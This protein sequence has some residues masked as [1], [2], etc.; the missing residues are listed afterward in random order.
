MTIRTAR[1]TFAQNLSTD[2][3]R[4]LVAS[5]RKSA[6]GAIVDDFKL[7][8]GFLYTQVRAI[9]ARVNQNYDGWPS[10]E[11]KK[12]YR[13]FLGKPDFV[14]HQNFDPSKARGRVVAARYVESGNDKFIEVIQEIDAQRFPKL[15]N[16]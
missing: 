6:N 2:G 10:T 12:S 15:A 1:P 14:N 13:T 4:R 7:K 3:V 16:Y 8:P 11:L 9:S 5:Y